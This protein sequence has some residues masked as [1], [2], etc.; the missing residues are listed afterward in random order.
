MTVATKK[1]QGRRTVRYASRSGLA[2]L[3]TAIGWQSR[4]SKRAPHPAFGNISNDEW[5]DFNLRHFEMHMSFVIPA[6]E[7]P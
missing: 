4:E 7:A 2:A 5:N 3:R 6:G 1:V